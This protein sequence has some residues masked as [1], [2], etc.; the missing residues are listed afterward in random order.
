MAHAYARWYRVAALVAIDHA[1][2]VSDRE[3][4]MAEIAGRARAAMA[5]GA[6]LDDVLRTFREV[7]GLR[8]IEATVALR[9]IAPID[10][11]CAKLLVDNFCDGK[12]YDLTLADLDLLADAPRVGGV[13]F[14]TRRHRDDAIVERR[15]Y[16]LY[17][18]HPTSLT[19][20]RI[21]ASATPLDH[22]PHEAG[23]ITGASVTFERVTGDVRQA[24]AAWPT[25]IRLLRDE[26]DTLLIQFLRARSE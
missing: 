22:M 11:C 23:S 25:E 14:F 9:E 13:D 4:R 24:A 8:A 15:P 3:R 18:R 10:L 16:V 26:P 21:A 12:R 6:T 1:R 5:H 7:E 19:S 2:R 17:A 20:V